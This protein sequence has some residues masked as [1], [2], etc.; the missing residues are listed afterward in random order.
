MEIPVSVRTPFLL[1]Y[2]LFLF[3]NATR[4]LSLPDDFFP[5]NHEIDLHI[6]KAAFHYA[7]PLDFKRTNSKRF[8][9]NL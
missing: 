5:L 7:I 1:N 6:F 9:F 4:I 2:P 3:P 8:M